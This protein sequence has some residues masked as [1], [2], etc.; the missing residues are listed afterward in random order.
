MYG[1][2]VHQFSSLASLGFLVC[3]DT[4][5]GS[6]LHETF[7]IFGA[8]ESRLLGLGIDFIAEAVKG[9]RYFSTDI[10]GE[11]AG[12][13]RFVDCNCGGLLIVSTWVRME[14]WCKVTTAT[15]II[16]TPAIAG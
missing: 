4:G 9:D 13:R 8:V 1:I 7:C 5:C 10:F 11:L 15:L 6:A 2:P 14:R 16:T 12:L 3:V